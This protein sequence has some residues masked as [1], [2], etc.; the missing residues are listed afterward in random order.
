MREEVEYLLLQGSEFLLLF[1]FLIHVA[2]NCE[3]EDGSGSDARLLTKKRGDGAKG[4]C[5][6]GRD[7]L[8][9]VFS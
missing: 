7:K 1:M 8:L 9:W 6:Q 3:V 2:F 4:G 5:R